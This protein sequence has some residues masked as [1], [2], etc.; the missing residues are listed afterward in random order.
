MIATKKPLV[1]KALFACFS[2]TF[3]IFLVIFPLFT[4]S[5]S[6]EVP[7]FGAEDAPSVI[8]LE[9]VKPTPTPAKA[10]INLLTSPPSLCILY[11]FRRS[12]TSPITV[13]SEVI[14]PATPAPV[15][16]FPVIKPLKNFPIFRFAVFKG[17]SSSFILGKYFF[18]SKEKPNNEPIPKYMR[19]SFGLLFLIAS[20]ISLSS[21]STVIFSVASLCMSCAISSYC[22]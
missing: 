11:C 21:V 17:L 15:S 6:V 3:C 20:S 4:A 12:L 8:K 9:A 1:L 2:R 13:K 5:L 22:Q 18:S 10:T 14:A 16:P 19:A 7:A